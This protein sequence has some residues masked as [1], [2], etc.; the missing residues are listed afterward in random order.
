[1][2]RLNLTA[3]PQWL[4]LAADLYPVNDPDWVPPAEED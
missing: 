1:M 2:I 3:T 4:D